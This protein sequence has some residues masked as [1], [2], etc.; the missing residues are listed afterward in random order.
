[1][2]LRQLSYFVKAAETLHFTESA[3]ALFVT[4]S[5]LSQQIKQLE[6]ELNVLLFDRVGKHVRLTEAGRIFLDH[7]RQTLLDAEKGKQ[8]VRDLQNLLIGELRIGVTYAFSSLVLPALHPFSVKYPGI[9]LYIEY[10]TVDELEKN[11]RSAGLD[12]ILAFH[13]NPDKELNLQPLFKSRLVMVVSKKNELAGLKKISLKELAAMDL[14]LPGK[15]FSSRNLLNELFAGINMKPSVRIELNDVN[16]LLSLIEMG[17]DAT[18]L[19]EKALRG[20]ASLTAIPISGRNLSTQSF[21]LTQRGV[22][23]KKAASLFIEELV[24]VM[25]IT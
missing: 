11:L 22:Y 9:K 1:M 23:Q 10:G 16:S 21:I 3:A 7:A 12:L 24:K 15:G 5:T 8:A 2:E 25:K 14:I 4:Q 6:E 19:D 20:R 17:D 13:R 18:V